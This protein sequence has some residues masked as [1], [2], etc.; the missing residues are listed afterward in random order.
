MCFSLERVFKWKR[1]PN[2]E[3]V[4]KSEKF[5]E[6]LDVQLLGYF[7]MTLEM[8]RVVPGILLQTHRYYYVREVLSKYT[9]YLEFRK[10]LNNAWKSDMQK[11]LR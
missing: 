4:D 5:N 7:D 8:S 1:N 6:Y 11:S 9:A 3:K 10:I 2:N